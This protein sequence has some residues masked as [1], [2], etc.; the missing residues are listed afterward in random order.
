VPSIFSHAMAA[1][2]IGAV[3]APKPLIRSFLAWGALVAVLPDVDIIGPDGIDALGGHRG[4]THS[5]TFAALVGVLAGWIVRSD[6]R[7]VHYK[8]IGLFIGLATATHGALDALT[9]VSRGVQFLSPFS[10]QRYRLSPSLIRSGLSELVWLF[11]PLLVLTATALYARGL[12]L[13]RVRRET[14]LSIRQ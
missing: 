2:A 9:G 5:L 1:A 6:E 11:I 3:M 4:F 12:R 14:P 13:P 10:M 7:A 8:R